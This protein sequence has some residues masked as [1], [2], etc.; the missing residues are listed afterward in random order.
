MNVYVLDWRASELAG[1][2]R[3]PGRVGLGLVLTSLGRR[4]PGS[5]HETAADTQPA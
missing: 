2:V 5:R 1:P 4:R 3:P